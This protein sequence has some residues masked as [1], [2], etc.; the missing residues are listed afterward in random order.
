MG[1]QSAFTGAL[2]DV[3]SRREVLRERRELEKAERARE[4]EEGRKKLIGAIGGLV[5][6]AFG[7]IGSF[8][9][10]AGGELIT[11]ALGKSE[12]KK[13]SGGKFNRSEAGEINRALSDYDRESNIANALNIGTKALTSFMMAGGVEGL[14][15]TLEGGG[16][17]KDFAT[18]WGTGEDAKMSLAKWLGMSGEEKA[19]QE[20]SNLSYFEYV[21]GIDPTKNIGNID[22]NEGLYTMGNF[23]M[24]NSPWSKFSQLEGGFKL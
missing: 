12:Q 3:D 2:L 11:D 24:G 19:K 10:S 18:T 17:L 14:K 6:S 22:A 1:Y 21:L 20:L 8:I 9:G 5:G 13:V 4:K 23:G 16:S 15:E 7:P